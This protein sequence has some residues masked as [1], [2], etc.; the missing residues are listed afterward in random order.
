MLD[1]SLI[2]IG[3]EIEEIKI[4]VD[5]ALHHVSP[6]APHHFAYTETVIRTT[7]LSASEPESSSSSFGADLRFE[8]LLADSAVMA[9][10]RPPFGAD[11]VVYV[12]L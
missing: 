1:H 9:S 2:N 12:L 5:H 3:V 7:S 8:T 4:D 6:L 11:I 10:S